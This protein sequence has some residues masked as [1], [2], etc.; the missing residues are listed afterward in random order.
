M[1]RGAPGFLCGERPTCLARPLAADSGTSR[2][3]DAGTGGRRCRQCRAERC[4]RGEAGFVLLLKRPCAVLTKLACDTSTF[5]PCVSCT[6]M[7][8]DSLDLATANETEIVP[9][10]VVRVDSTVGKP[11]T[12]ELR[13]AG[14]VAA[15]V[16]PVN[17]PRR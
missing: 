17:S 7:L 12:S 4:E 2:P 9:E 1:L 15:P 11:T 16:Q 13:P 6:R 8:F 14:S 10:V 5:S 3:G